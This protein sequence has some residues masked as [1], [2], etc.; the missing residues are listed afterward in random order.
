MTSRVVDIHRARLNQILA[1]AEMLANAATRI[2]SQTREVLHHGGTLQCQTQM[3][4]LVGGLARL[5]KDVGVVE[6]LQS[7]GVVARRKPI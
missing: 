7:D 4:F 2:V 3:H 1:E 6:Q 5:L